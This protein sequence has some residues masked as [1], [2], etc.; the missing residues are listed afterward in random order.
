M[1][2]I[3]S[4]FGIILILFVISQ[5]FFLNSQRNIETYA[6]TI[7]DSYETIE[8]RQYEASLF[9]SVQMSSNNYRKTSSK[10]FSVLAGYIFGSNNKEEKIAMTS[11]VAMSLKDST[12]MLF[13]VPKKYTRDNLPVP[14]DSRIEFKNIPEKRVAA[15]SFGG[16][17]NDLKIASFKKK[18]IDVL[19]SKGIKYTDN[20]YFLG[21]NAPMEVF[22]RKNEIIV[23]LE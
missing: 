16:W 10:G 12:T 22:N 13:L 19:N 5:L 2:I 14:N 20:F 7:I 8:I 23:E 9:T 4:I 15:I 3:L 17:A 1:K 11:P 6:F 21:Y 18:L